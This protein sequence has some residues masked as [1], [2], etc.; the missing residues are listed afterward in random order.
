M[1]DVMTETGIEKFE[2][3]VSDNPSVM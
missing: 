1:E 2:A 3:A